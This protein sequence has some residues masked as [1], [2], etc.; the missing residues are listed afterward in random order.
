MRSND[1]P[2]LFFKRNLLSLTMYICFAT[3][4]AFPNNANYLLGSYKYT[5]QIEKP[6]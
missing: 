6:P 2:H 4:F 5:T 1:F 3:A